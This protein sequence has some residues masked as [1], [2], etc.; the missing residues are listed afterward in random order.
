MN[1]FQLALLFPFIPF[2]ALLIIE[3]LL[4]DNDDDDH[5]D[6]TLIPAYAGNK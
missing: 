2:L 6:G 3:A 4:P 5:G 1:E